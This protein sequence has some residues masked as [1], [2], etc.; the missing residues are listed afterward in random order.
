MRKGVIFLCSKRESET[1]IFGKFVKSHYL[2]MVKQCDELCWQQYLFRTAFP[3]ESHL[4]ML[5]SIFIVKLLS[6]VQSTILISVSIPA[7]VWSILCLFQITILTPS[8]YIYISRSVC[9]RETELF[10]PSVIY[11]SLSYINASYE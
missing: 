5:T 8:L 2:N 3:S 1:K 7:I 4:N 9:T 6:A 11:S 10:I